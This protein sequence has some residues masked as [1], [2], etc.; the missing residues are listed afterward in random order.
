MAS[1][2]LPLRFAAPVSSTFS[3]L[4]HPKSIRL[5][6]LVVLRSP[7]SNVSAIGFSI[8]QFD[9]DACPEYHALS[10]TW[11]EACRVD[12]EYT[13]DEKPPS[14]DGLCTIIFL[15]EIHNATEPASQAGSSQDSLSDGK[16]QK[17]KLFSVTRN[18]HDGLQQ[19]AASGF[20]G[21]WL[22]ID[23]IC[24]DQENNDEK[25]IQVALMGDIYSTA[26]KVIIWL[27]ADTRDLGEFVWL[28][29][30]FLF[31]MSK[32]LAVFGIEDLKAQTP[33]SQNILTYSKLECP[34]GDLL[35]CFEKYLR[36]C[37]RRRWF[38]RIWVV[39]ETV[40]AR[41]IVVQCGTM[42]LPWDN[43][44]T[45]G[46]TIKAL[47]W[48]SLIAP[49]VTNNAFGRAICD[50]TIRLFLVKAHLHAERQRS[51]NSHTSM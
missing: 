43:V 6:Q 7:T 39:Q 9:L 19:L 35:T 11:G 23:A 18:L 34:F 47:G 48:Q 8:S 31:A 41:D 22:W 16:Q 15:G 1:V 28:C 20:L 44:D 36:F 51:S 38:S 21:K 5:L 40:L 37:R 32:Y 45:L 33:F 30:D 4:L 42:S 25:A 46:R 26:S 12:T 27:G 49:N 24:I 3:Q 2:Q 50:E 29:T 14:T 13:E 10:Y 17:G